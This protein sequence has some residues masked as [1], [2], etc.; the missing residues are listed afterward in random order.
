M[1]NN[2]RPNSAA[3]DAFDKFSNRPDLRK[4]KYGALGAIFLAIAIILAIIF[5]GKILSWVFTL[6]LWGLAG[7]FAIIFAILAGV[8][9]YRCHHS[10]W[11][12]RNNNPF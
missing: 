9:I 6:I 7:V 4:F 11:D 2:F 3:Q 5:L 1:E 8:F 10:Y 12:E